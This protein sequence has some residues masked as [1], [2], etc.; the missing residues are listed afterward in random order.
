MHANPAEAI[1]AAR[2]A[3]QNAVEA[4]HPGLVS[5]FGETYEAA[6][7]IGSGTEIV[8]GG[9][10]MANESI[11]ARIRCNLLETAPTPGDRI[12]DQSTEKGYEIVTVR[13]D[14]DAWAIRGAIFPG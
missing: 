2:A 14:G 4:R 11:A 13:R 7:V 8:D 9:G 1:R 12:I 3:T 10:R 5:V 6:V